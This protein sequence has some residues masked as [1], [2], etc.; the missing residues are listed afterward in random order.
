APRVGGRGVRIGSARLDAFSC[1]GEVEAGGHALRW[2]LTVWRG[3]VPAGA[4]PRRAAP[5]APVC[6]GGDQPPHPAVRAS[7]AGRVDGSILDLTEVPAMQ[8]HLWGHSR[9]PAWAWARCG[10]FAEDPDASIDLLDVRGPGGLR[11]PMLTFRFRGAVHR[12]GELPW[13]PLADS[14]PAAPAWHFAA[15][16]GSV[17]VDGVARAAPEQMVQA[18]YHEPDGSH[19]H[20]V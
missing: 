12:F 6:G 15:H 5:L 16:D 14:Q 19:L 10:A 3:F 2:P 4:I 1:N 13:M 8:G 11:Y 17:A 20:C 18:P 7:R 9:W